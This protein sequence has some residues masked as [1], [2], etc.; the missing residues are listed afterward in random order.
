L[1][2]IVVQQDIRWFNDFYVVFVIF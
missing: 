1:S 2:A